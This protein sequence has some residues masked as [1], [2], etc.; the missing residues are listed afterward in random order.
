MTVDSNF[1][2]GKLRGM[3]MV[4]E[5][6]SHQLELSCFPSLDARF[7]YLYSSVSLFAG[8]LKT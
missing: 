5:N 3:R 1:W 2:N 8:P 4:I 6:L 7:S